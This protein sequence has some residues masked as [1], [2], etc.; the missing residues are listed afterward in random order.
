[1]H[2]SHGAKDPSESRAAAPAAA[3]AAG[4]RA[5]APGRRIKAP[6]CSAQ[7][8]AQSGART[9]ARAGRGNH[10]PLWQ[11]EQRSAPKSNSKGTEAKGLH[12]KNGKKKKGYL[13]ASNGTLLR[14]RVGADPR[15]GTR[16]GQGLFPGGTGTESPAAPLPAH[17]HGQ[18][19]A[20]PPTRPRG[21]K[22]CDS[23]TAKHLSFSPKARSRQFHF[24][25]ARGE[26]GEPGASTLSRSRA[27]SS[28]QM[29]TA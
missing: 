14:H 25:G 19:R 20:S 21:E 28:A 2:P 23:N 17:S 11:S 26:A 24:N 16:R 3:M 5:P 10:V 7:W 22:G 4:S 13:G 12:S 8:P 6:S 9:A 1:M 29:S 27:T 15:A 18:P